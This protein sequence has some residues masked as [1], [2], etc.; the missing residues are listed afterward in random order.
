[1]VRSGQ[2]AQHIER[3]R[4]VPGRHAMVQPNQL[5]I[6]PCSLLRFIVLPCLI[7]LAGKVHPTLPTQPSQPYWPCPIAR[8]TWLVR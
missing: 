3:H 1:M 6:H 2:E 8:P 7:H 4:W 5:F